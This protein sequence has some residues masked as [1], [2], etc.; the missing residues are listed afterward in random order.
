MTTGAPSLRAALA[1]AALA[2]C[3]QVDATFG[4]MPGPEALA[5][6]RPGLTTRAELLDLLGPPEEYAGPGAD[7]G[8]RAHDPQEARVLDERDLFG[9]EVLTWVLELRRDRAFIVPLL[10]SHWTTSH[11][12]GRVTALL[13]GRGVVAALGVEPAP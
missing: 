2:G 13:D 8:L 11:R 4:R 12:T 1:A 7:L 5:A 6:V 10:Y 9:R 3:V